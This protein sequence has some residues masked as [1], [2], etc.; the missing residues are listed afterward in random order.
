[1]YSAWLLVLFGA[2]IGARPQGSIESSVQPV[3]TNQV[4]DFEV[5]VPPGFLY[6]RTIP[7]NPDHGFAIDLRDQTTVWVDASYTESSSTDEEV[8]RLTSGCR[9]EKRQ[10]QMLGTMPALLIH[11]SCPARP[12][13]AAYREHLVVSVHNQAHRAPIRFEI[14]VM[15]K[16]KRIGASEDDLLMKLVAGFRLRT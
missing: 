14:G 12:S 11:F 6:N 1:M 7:P 15:A 3:Y 8:K 9:I 10:P 16:G 13:A 4:Y 5:R 2:V